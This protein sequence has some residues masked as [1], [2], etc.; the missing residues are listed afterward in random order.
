MSD[1]TATKLRNTFCLLA[2]VAFV[3]AWVDLVPWWITLAVCLPL[4]FAAAVVVSIVEKRFRDY[5]FVE[6]P[7][8]TGL[9]PQT[10]EFFSRSSAALEELQF[11][12]IG[13]FCLLPEPIPKHARIYASP[14]GDCFACLYTHFVDT[15][16]VS[17][18]AYCSVTADGTY[19]ESACYAGKYSLNPDLPLRFRYLD[20]TASTAE[21]L[22]QHRE[23]VEQHTTGAQTSLLELRPDQF[24]QVLAHGH[25]LVHW[26]QYQAACGN[27]PSAADASAWAEESPWSPA[28]EELAA[29]R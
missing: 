16:R 4:T 13:D 14:D 2:L 18:L 29:A 12:R 5:V 26:E 7:A 3:A 1:A 10:M 19:I 21:T 8:L 20:D 27:A 11:E 28:P 24:R 6:Q 25:R 9:P 23:F 15:T 22:R 17:Y